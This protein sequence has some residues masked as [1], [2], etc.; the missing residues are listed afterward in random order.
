[1]SKLWESGSAAR[2]S[3]YSDSWEGSKISHAKKPCLYPA[4]KEGLVPGYNWV[5]EK[6][7]QSP[8][9]IWDMLLSSRY[10]VKHTTDTFPK[11]PA[12]KTRKLFTV[13]L[14]TLI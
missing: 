5:I 12:E 7:P 4:L 11:M 8:R 10:K 9:K 2:S 3:R 13:F 14:F 6:R 1:M